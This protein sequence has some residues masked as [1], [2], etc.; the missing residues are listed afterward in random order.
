[1]LGRIASDGGL[2]RRVPEQLT[3]LVECPYGPIC[4]HST[5]T[6]FAG[7]SRREISR[8]LADAV[9]ARGIVNGSRSVARA[10]GSSIATIYCDVE[11]TV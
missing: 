8:P 2:E 7:I 10:L 5:T 6:V 4:S 11:N 3:Q 9:H 1:V